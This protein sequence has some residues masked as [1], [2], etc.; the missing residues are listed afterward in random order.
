MLFERTVDGVIPFKS[1][2][3]NLDFKLGHGGV[4]WLASVS[5]PK[6]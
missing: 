4:E 6:K 5:L 2:K 3:R 1:S